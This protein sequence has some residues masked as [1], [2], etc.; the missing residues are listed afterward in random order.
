MK[1]LLDTHVFLW[2]NGSPEKLTTESQELDESSLVV[3]YVVHRAP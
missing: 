3:L 2:L 1:L